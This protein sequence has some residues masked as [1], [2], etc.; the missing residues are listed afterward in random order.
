V[1]ASLEANVPSRLPQLA[2]AH[3]D[4]PLREQPVAVVDDQG[5]D[6]S[7]LA[8]PNEDNFVSDASD[9]TG[10]ETTSS[11]P[12]QR[13]RTSDAAFQL[14]TEMLEAGVPDD[15]A[16]QLLDRV[17]HS[18]PSRFNHDYTSLRESLHGLVQR[19]IRGTGPVQVCNRK[20][21][22]V[23]L[24]GPTGVGKTTT[25]AKLAANIRLREK[26][27]VGL[28]TVDTY[29]IAAVEQLRTYADIIDLPMEVIS[30]PRETKAAIAKLSDTD[31][32]LMDT[33]GRSPRDDVKIQELK[34]ILSEA[35]ADEIHL[36]LSSVSSAANLTRIV[37]RF[38]PVGVSSLLFTKLDESAMLG[39]LLAVLDDCRLPVSYLTRG[40]N[41][42]DDIE[43]AVSEKLASEIL[44]TT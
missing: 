14:F 4:A 21:R 3:I 43:P 22:L 35:E 19:M 7:Q 16:R 20:Q 17:E 26:R 2:A 37:E 30:S 42:P 6:L 44:A 1:T 13:F 33:A 32:I 39:H 23:A 31:L 12:P 15:L 18:Q 10:P 11:E 8:P 24:V 9:S 28:I 5:I 29:R 27:R 41:V 34:H 40:Q 38:Q 25:I 36:V